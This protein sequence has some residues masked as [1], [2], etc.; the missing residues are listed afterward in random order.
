[1]ASES[2]EFVYQ[3]E[4]NQLLS[5]I[6]NTFYSKKEVFVRELISNASDA[7][8]KIRYLSLTDKSVLG[9]NQDLEIR[10]VADKENKTLTI[11]DD[12]IGMTKE[13]MIKNLGTI[14]H[15]G[16]RQF[17]EKLQNAPAASQDAI[18][19]IG[20]FGMGFYSAFLIA[21]KVEVTSK[22]NDDDEYT[23]ASAASG[24]FTITKSL[25]PT[26][27]RGTRIV[28]HVKE[29]DME[30]LEQSKI[31]E[32][33]NTHSSYIS[34]PIKL[35]TQEEVE[36]TEDA[37]AEA[38]DAE[39]ADAEQIEQV[40]E[41]KNEPLKKTITKN[42]WT[43]LNTQKPIWTRKPSEVTKEE[44]ASFYKSLT[45]DWQEHQA[46][47]HFNIE[48][49]MEMRAI[50]FTP[51]HPPYDMFSPDKKRKT[52]KLY[53]RRVFI[54]DEVELLPEHFNFVH[55]I[56]DSDDLPLNI[57][58]EML[59]QN[60]L[61]NVIKKNLVKKTV[62][63]FTDLQE[64][65]EE[66]MKFW[67]SFSK[68]IK[69][70]VHEDSNNRTKLTELLRF[71]TSKSPKDMTTLKD[72]VSRMVEGQANIYFMTGESQTAMDNSPFIEKLK[73]KNYEVIYMT[74]PIDEFM[75]QVLKEY[76]GKQFKSVTKEGLVLDEAEK[77]D[78]KDYE[79]LC[80]KVKDVLGDKVSKV[81]VSDR[82]VDTPC[83]LVTDE[84]G[85]SANMER[86]QK[87]QALRNTTA[88]A[89]MK[90]TKIMEL[91]VDH[92]IVA[93]IMTETDNKRVGNI[94]QILYETA[95]ISSGFTLEDPSAFAKRIHNILKIGL[96]SG[97]VAYE[98]ADQAAD[99]E[100]QAEA[101]QAEA[102]AVMAAAES[103]AMEELD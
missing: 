27:T 56:V 20:Q 52:I 94:V 54:S 40:E 103:I 3:A 37:E 88:F 29:G 15:S 47:K 8:D 97:E 66:Y 53:V 69:W 9:E 93:S 79:E 6:I 57:S 63:M 61:I 83:I 81:I 13:D 74:E 100:H 90:A 17:I 58:R 33:V 48:G 30:Y 46:V 25:T 65:D 44:Y 84:Y 75:M 62:E 92:P 1:M 28:L 5:L 73:K 26:I 101:E 72:Y 60:K 43:T 32:I 102:E 36:V 10:I 31:T 45:M 99:A 24:T 18:S 59:Q 77:R 85:W 50:L 41:V 42:V 2:E 78:P 7:L 67:N 86:I 4:I 35:E 76:D 38:A 51:G 80:K 22:H 95:M 89:Q 34:Y 21:D 55:G 70:A 64:N 68:N 12:G 39:A 23:W 14:A 87:S 19:L 98:D 91:N 49:Q 11:S 71:A 82:M 16:T 96:D